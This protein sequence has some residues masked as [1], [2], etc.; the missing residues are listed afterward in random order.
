MA[1]LMLT[2]GAVLLLTSVAFGAY[3]YFN[4]RRTTL[5]QLASVG[6]IIAANS[7][8][9]LAFQ[10]PDDA[11]EILSALA[12]EPHI[13]VAALYDDSGMLFSSY[14]PT[15]PS[16]RLPRA[17][18]E[19]G[20]RFE[21]SA[22][23]GYLPVVQGGR[24]LGT[25]HL[26]SDLRGL[27]ERVRRYLLIAALVITIALFAA[28]GLSSLL[29]R[30]ISHPVLALTRAARAISEHDDY[31]VRV[32]PRGDDELG[33]LT[34]AFNS[35]LARI[36]EQSGALRRSEAEFRDVAEIMPQIVWTAD[37]RGRLD[38]HNRRWQDYAGMD[39]GLDGKAFLH[40]EDYRRC[41]EEW[42]A[43]IRSGSRYEI[44][45]RLR[46][47]SD[48]A[49]RWHIGRA[50]P[51]RGAD[52]RITRWVGTCTDVEDLKHAEA[53]LLHTL[54]DLRDRNRD[55][56]DFAF[57]ASHD[58]QEPLRKIQIFS[59]RLLSEAAGT[60]SPKHL[61][62]LVRTNNAATRLRTLVQDLLAYT[63]V[64]ATRWAMAPVDL[65]A[66]VAE[67]L[68][69]L[70][71]S[72]RDCAAKVTVGPLPTIDC[73]ATQMRQM[74]QNLIANALK[75]RDEPRELEVGIGAKPIEIGDGVPGWEISVADTGIGMD[76]AH[77]ESIFAL[78]KRLHPRDR[79]QGTGIGLSI[80][81]RIVE[82]HRGTVRATGAPG[83]GSTF[84]IA[85][86][87]AQPGS[88]AM[89]QDVGDLS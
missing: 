85:L 29:Q 70:E 30:Q 89:P 61:D 79:Y 46:R 88:G 52:G 13:V 40:P 11:R 57:V 15:L 86:P 83:A 32:A 1:M 33:R 82:R 80:V 65:G 28:F 18:G 26:E 7:T 78:F 56:Q 25:F 19:D 66:V 17:P 21:A 76:P 34:L 37:S 23:V 62:L 45:Y 71:L 74:F 58:L 44:E 36:E 9:A 10:N 31:S 49:Y 16:G 75:F 12:A 48:G 6:G 60:L 81:R 54:A 3:E 39:A 53:R 27:D 22:A 68:D 84:V 59:D 24:R 43:S 51:L 2:S 73:D 38:Y 47:A 69:D 67:V 5:Q 14:P 77:T 42:R 72:I 55:L 63:N 20:F 50:S 87:A 4:F 8:A 41:V 35:M 64:Q